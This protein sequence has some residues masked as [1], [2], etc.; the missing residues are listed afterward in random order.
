MKRLLLITLLFAL[1]NTGCE[2]KKDD[3][4]AYID[5]EWAYYWT[6]AGNIVYLNSIPSINATFKWKAVW[7]HYFNDESRLEYKKDD[8]STKVVDLTGQINFQ[9]Q[10]KQ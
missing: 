2:D 3:T 6:G 4:P 10:A 5:C 9:Y 1:M 8:G 7:I